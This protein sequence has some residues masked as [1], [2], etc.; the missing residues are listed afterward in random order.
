MRRT[1]STRRGK[2]LA[3]VLALVVALGGVAGVVGAGS[4]AAAGAAADGGT[5]AQ[6]PAAALSDADIRA[7]TAGSTTVRL[8]PTTAT[9]AAGETQ[10]YDI[11]VSDA[12]GGVGA[13]TATISVDDTDVA[14]IGDVELNADPGV[15]TVDV[16]SDGSE[17]FVRA[18]LMDTDDS[19]SVTI[20]TVSVEGTDQGSTDVSLD[21]ESLGNEDGDPYD[22][23]A[24]PGSSLSVEGSADATPLSISA[25]ES[26]VEPGDQVDFEVRRGDDD[27]LVSATVHVGGEAYE[28]G[29][30]GVAT[31]RI[32]D[33]MGSDAGTITAV[34]SKE[35][36]DEESFRND[37]VTL[38]LGGEDA[39]T[40]TATP[41]DTETPEPGDGP[42]VTLRP[43]SASVG[44]GEETEWRLVAAGVDG[45]VG[46]V[47]AQ[48]RLESTETARIT[49][50]ELE[51]DAGVEQTEIQGDGA[52]AVI[53]GALMDTNDTGVAHIATLTVEGVESGTTQAAVSVDSLGDE[54]GNSYE[55]GSTP[56][57]TLSVGSADDGGSEG[58]TSTVVLSVSEMPNGF[59]RAGVTVR[60]AVD[61]SVTDT[62]AEMVSDSQLRVVSDGPRA[63]TVQAVDLAGDVDGFEEPRTIARLT[64]DQRLSADDVEIE[65]EN[66]QND[67]GDSVSGDRISVEVQA[68]GLFEESLPGADTGAAPTDPDGDGRYEDV[69]GDGE[70]TFDD[71]VALSFVDVTELSSEQV[72]ALD[73]DEDGDLDMDDA[74]A[75]AFE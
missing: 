75:L 35:A 71:A 60:T 25:D 38:D 11:V 26:T 33:E 31:V 30:D 59:E 74:V 4:V 20:G 3:V 13:V 61:A 37:S 54:D 16:E 18:A 53:R 51:G 36:T 15:E 64:Y 68:G 55:V 46:A 29:L 56:S 43:A 44:V 34:A 24:T 6:A 41:P 40:A 67:D 14:S 10:E 5:D 7:Q 48:I 70:V 39:G 1:D 12:E 28:T 45:G 27:A 19:G 22:V 62:Q 73:F 17:V 58:G 57:A 8:T 32:T 52:G 66:L 72:A 69:D 65:V 47:E 49:D 21:V 50:V 42:R 9:V 63:T 2:R 23:G